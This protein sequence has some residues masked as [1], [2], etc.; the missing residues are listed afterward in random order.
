M[1]H[2]RPHVLKYFTGI[3]VIIKFIV[4]ALGVYIKCCLPLHKRLSH[5]SI[6]YGSIVLTRI[7]LFLR[8][9]LVDKAKFVISLCKL[10]YITLF[11]YFFN[12]CQHVF[13]L[14]INIW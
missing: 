11:I 5:T 7:A 2:L 3:Y 9:R 12:D 8:I 14:L 4:Q 1:L 10:F 13:V 6:V